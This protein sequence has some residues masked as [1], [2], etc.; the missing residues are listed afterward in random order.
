MKDK[1]ELRGVVKML[2][3]SLNNRQ[4]SEYNSKILQQVV[5][6]PE[7][8]KAE[9]I[10]CY[11][12]FQSEVDTLPIIKQAML[13][14]KR[15]AVPKVNGDEMDFYEITSLSDCEEGT[16]HIMEPVTN[17]LMEP[18]KHM[19]TLMLVPGLAF[20]ANR[21]RMGYGK[22]YY[23]KYFEKYGKDRFI[24]AALAYDL[25]VIHEV[26]CNHLDVQMN[27]VITESRIYGK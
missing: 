3:K 25:Q 13:D 4:R 1:D 5:N 24:R 6:L 7:Y 10:F 11:L 12:T 2:R 19:T 17:K 22:G 15:V 20:D 26:P 27:Y 9:S 18:A 23:D 8:K 14:G 21:N 16:F